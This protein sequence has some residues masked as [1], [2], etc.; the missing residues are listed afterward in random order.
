MLSAHK[1]E[2]L[3]FTEYIKMPKNYIKEQ[4]M[5]ESFEML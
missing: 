3:L 1:G 2:N 4:V 5:W